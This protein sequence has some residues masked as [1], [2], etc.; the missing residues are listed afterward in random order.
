MKKLAVSTQPIVSLPLQDIL[1]PSPI[2]PGRGRL[3][4]TR[5]ANRPSPRAAPLCGRHHEEGVEIRITGGK[6]T[7]TQFGEWPHMCMVYKRN[8]RR[9]FRSIDKDFFRENFAG[10][11]SLVAP[12][13]LITA[14]HI[15]K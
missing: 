2:T 14:A 9:D 13:V 7:Q 3:P 1:D 15:L 10:G 6:R 11:A 5:P 8:A 4:P 12:G